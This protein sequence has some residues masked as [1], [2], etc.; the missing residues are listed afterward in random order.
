MLYTGYF[1]KV[2]EYLKHGL[3][4]VN[5]ALYPPKDYAFRACSSLYPPR[6]LLSHYKQR[7]DEAYFRKAYF[8][9]V[10]NKLHPETVYKQLTRHGEL[11]S[12]LLC[13]ESPEK[14][15]H[16]HLIAEW[17]SHSG[18]PVSEFF[19]PYAITVKPLF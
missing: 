9:D 17:F 8:Q 14:F 12:I 2:R 18:Y 4:P 19:D 11:K 5:I 7:Q 10:L 15:C 16:R 3:A 6:D 13:Y 1:A